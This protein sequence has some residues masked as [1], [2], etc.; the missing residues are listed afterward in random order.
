LKYP[1]SEVACLRGSLIGRTDQ[2]V[3][4]STDLSNLQQKNRNNYLGGLKLEYIFDNTVN[5]G[6]NLYNGWRYKIFGEY[7]QH[8][9]KKAARFFVI[10]LDVRYYKKIHRD[11]IWAN[12][13]AAST[14]FGTE[15][16]IYYLGG[17]DN[18]FS[19]KFDNSTSIDYSQNYQYQTVA[20]NMRGFYQN[21]RNGNSFAVFNSELRV[22]LFKYIMNRPLRSDFLT[23]FQ[24]VAFGDIGTAWT[25]A[26]PYSQ[27]NFLNTQTIQSGNLLIKI[28]NSKEPIVG[29]YGLGIRSRILGYFIRVDYAWGVADGRVLKPLLYVSLSLDF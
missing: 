11:L 5:R 3:N 26:S 16:L 6:L 9:D 19:P 2:E 18:W 14:S 17:V 25:G 24:V 7:Y 23:N 21:V 29:G 10:G 20:T 28:K 27:D 4:L 15:K 8:V 12:R 1:F 13:F 22:P